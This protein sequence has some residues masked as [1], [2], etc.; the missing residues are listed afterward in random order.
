MLSVYFVHGLGGHAFK[1]WSS[2]VQHGDIKTLKAWP[3]DFLPKRLMKDG[4]N[5]RIYSLGY[6]ANVIRKAAPNATIS[7][8]A[9]DLLAALRSDR[10]QVV[11]LVLCL[12]RC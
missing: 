12:T 9:E 2:D 1:T 10:S 5:A 6:N 11:L 4:V 7:S 3:R 8:A